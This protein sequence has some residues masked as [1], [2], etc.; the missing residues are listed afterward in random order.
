MEL[1]EKRVFGGGAMLRDAEAAGFDIELDDGRVVRVPPGRIRMY[2]AKSREKVAGDKMGAIL[3]PIEATGDGVR[4]LFPYD[5]AETIV[6]REGDRVEVMGE[7]E[8]A[9]DTA[10]GGG[11]RASAGILAPVGVPVLRAVKGE[12]PKVRIADPP[13]L[14]GE[15]LE[16]E[17]AASEE[18]EERKA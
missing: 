6:L 8:P 7:L 14:E 1:H 11:Y 17:D 18:E 3:E 9:A 5:F 16:E 12:A 4:P 10:A 15:A 13:S 2:G